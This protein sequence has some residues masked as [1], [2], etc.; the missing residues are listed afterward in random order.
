MF[1]KTIKKVA[2]FFSKNK[3]MGKAKTNKPAAS[4]SQA[5]RQRVQKEKEAEVK[6]HACGACNAQLSEDEL[7]DKP[8]I[9]PN[10]KSAA[11]E[12]ITKE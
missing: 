6:T 2:N 3:E 7:S 4:K 10:C 11:V 12:K 8:H 1:D 9:C 5:R